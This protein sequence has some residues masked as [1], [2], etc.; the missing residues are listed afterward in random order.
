MNPSSK[1]TLFTNAIQIET[2][3]I[4]ISS[5]FPARKIVS[6]VRRRRFGLLPVGVIMK[7]MEEVSVVPRQQQ[8]E[9][10]SGQRE[11]YDK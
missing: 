3:T 4:F 2:C 11:N 5:E 1:T 8:G 6:Q 9:K 10:A 7:W